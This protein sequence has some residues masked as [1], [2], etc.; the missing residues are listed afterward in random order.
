MKTKKN[1]INS[2]WVPGVITLKDGRKMPVIGRICT[3]TQAEK[4]LVARIDKEEGR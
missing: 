3:L 1:K 4:D 2:K